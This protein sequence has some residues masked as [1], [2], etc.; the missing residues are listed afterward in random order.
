MTA[1]NKQPDDP[2]NELAKLKAE[3]QLLA[4]RVKQLLKAEYDLSTTHK[5]LETQIDLYH[6]LHDLSGQFNTIFDAS[7]VLALVTEFVLYQLNFERCLLFLPLSEIGPWRVES[8]DGYYDEVLYQTISQLTL[9]KTDPIVLSL[10]LEG[11]YLM[12]PLDCDD[13]IL[14]T[15]GTKI[16]MDEYLLFPLGNLHNFMGILVVGNTVDNGAYHSRIQPDSEAVVGVANL[17]SLVTTKLD[18][19]NIYQALLKERTLLEAR[20]KQRTFHLESIAKFN[21]Q[22]NVILDF[23]QLLMTFVHKIKDSFDYYHVQ[24]FI[25]AST[26]QPTVVDGLPEKQLVM[27][28]GIGPAGATMK[29]EGYTVAFDDPISVVAQA[30][31]SGQIIRIDKIDQ[32]EN[33]QPHQLLPNT[34]AEMAV[35]IIRENKV[36]GVLDVHSAEVAG[37]DDADAT[38]L[39]SLVGHVAVAMTNAQ[40]FSSEQRQW[41]VAESLRQVATILNRSLERDTVLDGIM[42]ELRKVVEYDGASIFLREGTDL[43]LAR[44]AEYSDNY[45][46]YHIPINDTDP[47][48]EVFRERA[49]IIISDVYQDPRWVIWE[50]GDPIRTWMGTP[51]LIGDTILGVLALDNFQI[52]AYQAEDAQVLQSFADQAATAINNVHLFEAAQQAKESAE[53]ANQTKTE[54]LANMSH[55]LRTPLNGILGYTQVLKNKLNIPSDV[56]DGLHII[57]QSGERLLNL[58]TN[59]LDFSKLETQKMTLNPTKINLPLFL[60]DIVDIISKQAHAKGIS[61]QY[62]PHN[63]PTGVMVDGDRLG[64]ILFNLL[65]NA[66]KFTQAGQVILAVHQLASPQTINISNYQ[67]EQL[68]K[69]LNN[70]ATVRFEVADTGVGLTTD[71]L[72]TMFEAFEQI[73]D[74]YIRAEGAG[75]GLTITKNLVELMGSTLQ[76]ESELHQGTRFW[77][78]LSLPRV[79][80]TDSY[81]INMIDPLL[82]DNDSEQLDNKSHAEALIPPI[83]LLTELHQ[84]TLWGNMQRIRE[85]TEPLIEQGTYR[86]F[87]EQVEQLAKL[88]DS[89]GILDLVEPYL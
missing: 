39:R 30:A 42:V 62:K 27:Q 71:Q 41:R 21:E 58:I 50:D 9:S 74:V 89:Q 4:T 29:A 3:N 37:L 83:E 88:Y 69:R 14:L 5:R 87:A 26:S 43:V 84:L 80:I 22:L 7:K 77:F 47:T 68:T 10:M 86:P 59:I 66:V 18:N 13:P 49:T 64:Q 81:L 52:N 55:E 15:F 63:V 79:E 17:V 34:Q 16:A 54:F 33:W 56:Q 75:L 25:V 67:T 40:L 60:E 11:S 65:D 72:E 36:V 82:V 12:C 23:N 8:L 2:A 57:Q 76:V 24:I 53:I 35:P 6:R 19:I 28:A 45:T 70:L 48:A 31:R 78:Q 73:G 20:V 1:T 61:F 51:L 46:G 85:W 44:G 32:V 38:L